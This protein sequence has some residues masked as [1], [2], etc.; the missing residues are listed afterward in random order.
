MKKV[1]FGALM[2]LTFAVNAQK[3][4]RS[5]NPAGIVTMEYQYTEDQYGSRV[6]NGYFKK[7]YNDGSPKVIGQ[8]K[9]DKAVGKWKVFYRN[10]K[11]QEVCTY[12]NDEYEGER[13]LFYKNGKMKQKMNYVGGKK[14][15]VVYEYDEQ[16]TIE[17]ETSY[18][19]GELNLK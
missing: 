9:N 5:K 16:G 6:V 7:Y 13:L 8:Q 1:L 2:L 17:G 12:V 10:G 11:I 4:H 15:G 18:K 14:D 3:V 19:N